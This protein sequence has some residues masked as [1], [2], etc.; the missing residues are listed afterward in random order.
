MNKVYQKILGVILIFLGEAVSI[1]AEVSAARSYAD[2]IPF[3]NVFFSFFLVM[4]VGAGFLISG[5]MLGFKA[6]KNIWIVTVTSLTSVLI[7]EATL[8]LVIFGQFPT[9]G[10]AIGFVLGTIGFIATMVIK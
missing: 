10:A 9:T 4:T 3:L 6:F 1:Y 7:M 2:Q 5:Y 8:A